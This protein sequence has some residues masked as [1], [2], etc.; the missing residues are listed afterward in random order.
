[1]F[2]LNWKKLNKNQKKVKE[3]NNLNKINIVNY[4]LKKKKWKL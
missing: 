4:Y 1:M 2:N 3:S